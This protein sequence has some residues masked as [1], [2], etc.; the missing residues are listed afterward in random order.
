MENIKLYALSHFSRSERVIWALEELQLNYQLIRLDPTKGE[1]KT[2]EFSKLNPSQKVP[3]LVHEGKVM[4]ES[5]AIIEYLNDITEHKPLVPIGVNDC[6]FY[7]KALFYGLSEL[8][9]Y[10]WTAEQSSRLKQFFN[11]PEGTY[12]AMIEKVQQ[13]IEFIWPWF[14]HKHF[15]IKQFSVADIFYHS[16]I[17]WAKKHGIEPPTHVKDY[18][19][20]LEQRESYK[21]LKNR[22]PS[23]K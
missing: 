14:E 12:E 23:N 9:V 19:S 22:I 10:L 4:T 18:L 5:L 11:W 3:V 16:L 17:N 20:G 15:L 13:N 1:L 2:P 7:H 21:A 6:Y 8:E